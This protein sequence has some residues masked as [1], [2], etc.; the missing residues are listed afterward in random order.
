MRQ[1]GDVLLTLTMDVRLAAYV[2]VFIQ[3]SAKRRFLFLMIVIRALVLE[4]AC[5]CALNSPALFQHPHKEAEMAS[6][7][8]DSSSHRLL[9]D[10]RVIELKQELDK[11]GLDKSGVKAK[12]IERLEEVR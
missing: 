8:V 4:F 2:C 10:L 1:G 7:G 3:S 11:R 12:L 5:P 6:G 9:S